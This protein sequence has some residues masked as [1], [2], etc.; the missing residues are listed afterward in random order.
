[1]LP[2]VVAGIVILL[3]VC[4]LARRLL[5]G[6]RSVA[7]DATRFKSF[8]LI[9]KITVNHNSYIFRFA[10]D[11]PKQKLGL[12][13]G[14]HVHI[15][16]AVT[17]GAGKTAVVQHAYTPI[18]SDEDLGHVDFLIKVYRR[19]VHPEFP[20]GGRLTQH[21]DG[22]PLGSAVEM[23]GPAGRFEYIGRGL[24]T[25]GGGGAARRM[26]V[27]AFAMVAGGSGITPM[28]Q[29]IRAILRDPHD[30]TGVSLVYANQT[31]AD[32]LLRGELDECARDG[33][34]RV[35]HVLS[36]ERP[37]GW[38][39]STGHVDE[40]ILRAQLPSPQG[41]CVGGGRVVALMCG[42]QL[43]IQSAVKPCLE[44]IGFKAEDM[45]VF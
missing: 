18:S 29:L 37:A 13:I 41:S 45:F 1:M 16:A 3:S 38:A 31:E 33:R 9:D 6:V 10:L 14:K 2:Y 25:I 12:P 20:D 27:G 15:R 8:K 19:N 21:L 30:R 4:L 35:W 36:R 32:I 44:K 11:T 5:C 34:V 40:E 42:P 28:L 17:D 22:L 43:M 26:D 7:L 23:R 24:C 39:Y